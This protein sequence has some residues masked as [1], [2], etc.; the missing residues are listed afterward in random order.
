MILIHSIE[1]VKIKKTKER[2]FSITYDP[3]FS[4]FFSLYKIK[5]KREN[6]IIHFEC[7]SFQSLK[8]FIDNST[9]KRLNYD[10]TIKMI[11][12]I[13]FIIKSLEQKEKAILSFSLDDITV[14]DEN[15]FFFINTGKILPI[16]NNEITLKMPIDIK[17]SF[18]TPDVDWKHL[19]IKTHFTTGIYSFALLV[20]Y[21]TTKINY[22]KKINDDFFNPIYQ[23]KL[24]YFLLRCLNDNP[25]ERQFLYI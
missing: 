6:D 20:I 1:T 23:T 13:G 15:V 2:D 21:A 8:E 10:K 19:P 18:L 16:L 25:E 14:I 4:F 24:Y 22:Q 7:D 3:F 11:Y 9:T 17:K 5:Y 12:D